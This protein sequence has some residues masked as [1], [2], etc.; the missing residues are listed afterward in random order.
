[1]SSPLRVVLVGAEGRMG[2]FADEL[3]G[4]TPGFTVTAR[5]DQGDDLAAGLRASEAEVGLD[6]TVAG[7]GAPHGLAMLAAG[8]RPVIGTSGVSPA[9]TA[10][11]DADARARGLGGL[12]VPN[13]SLGI[14]LLQRA[15]RLAVE[16]FPRLEII[17]EH[18]EH[19]RDAPSGTAADTAAR[20]AAA[21]GRPPESIP[22]HSVR[23]PG[24]YAHHE[25]RLGGEGE[26]LSIRHDM[27][28]PTAFG[29]GL[30]LALRYAATAT[31]VGCGLDVALDASAACNP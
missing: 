24:R 13:F 4:A 20:L 5:L 27:S 28:G 19:K 12:V 31:G 14:Q 18:H 29:P 17:E 7:L 25:V 3:L 11:L 2:R 9:D 8:V 6:V 16:S 30:L 1:M 23:L 26:L 15:A 22:I 10:A 21:L